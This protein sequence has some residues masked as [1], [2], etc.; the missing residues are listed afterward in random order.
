MS[1]V[2][3]I[4]GTKNEPGIATS[5]VKPRV[6]ITNAPTVHA[7]FHGKG[8]SSTASITDY[9]TVDTTAPMLR[10]ISGPDT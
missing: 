7:S 8:S 4:N 9:D 10:L 1:V 6:I 2:N 5:T 3:N